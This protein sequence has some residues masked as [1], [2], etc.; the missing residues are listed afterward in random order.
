[1]G[2]TAQGRGRCGGGGRHQAD[3]DNGAARRPGRRGAR[4]G[5]PVPGDGPGKENGRTRDEPTIENRPKGTT[6]Y[7]IFFSNSKPSIDCKLFEIRI[8]FQIQMILIINVNLVAHNQYKRKLCNSMR[9]NN[10]IS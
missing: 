10:Q 4:Q 2:G 5:I 9:C 3:G 7:K 1:M 8:K 6:G